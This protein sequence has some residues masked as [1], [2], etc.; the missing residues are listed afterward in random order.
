M[1]VTAGPLALVGLLALGCGGDAGQAERVWGRHGVIAGDVVRPRAIAIDRQDRVFVVDCTARVQVW[2]RDGKYVGPS[3]QTPDYRK[4]RPSGLGIDRDGNLLVCDSHY[5]CIRVYSA[6]GQLLRT[7]GGQSGSEPGQLGY[8]ADVVQDADGTYFVAEFGE[9]QR[10]SAFDADGTFLRCWGGEGTE[11][12]KF[13]RPRGLALGPDGLLYV[14]DAC[15]HRV[16]VFDKQGRLQRV[17][18]GP[19]EGRG[20]FSYPFDVAVT[21]EGHIAVAELG[22][23]RVQLL[24]R[25]GES[26]AVWG[27]PGRG[28]GQLHC[29]WALAVDSRGAIHVVDTENHRVQRIR[30]LPD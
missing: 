16:Q 25:D 20:E 24:S 22:N 18:G 17:L 15:N 13:S 1:R 11:P 5:H 6:D 2:D 21:P 14:C 30:L 28:P 12:G 10:I 7:L 19:G 3:W 8:V 26:L 9:N 23:H 29:P 27:G 4:G